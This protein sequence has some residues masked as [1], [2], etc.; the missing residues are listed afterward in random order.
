MDIPRG[1]VVSLVSN[2]GDMQA[3]IDVDV[4]TTCPR[5]ASGKGC[6][7]GILAAG[8]GVRRIQV[9]VDPNLG[10]E[11][12]DVVNLTLAPQNVL[13]AALIVYGLPMAGAIIGVGIAYTLSLGDTG[14][15]LAALTG[16]ATG[17]LSGRWRL[18]QTSCL[19]QFVP[20]IGRA[21]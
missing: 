3:T 21:L 18:R 4:T 19:R 20:K 8:S 6:G 17:M 14:A 7:A 11:E 9:L 5:C 12:G 13:R 10:L 1:T 16:L 15:A 2:A